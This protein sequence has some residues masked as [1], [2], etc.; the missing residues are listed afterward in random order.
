[1]AQ[2]S[3]NQQ[4]LCL[5]LM[6]PLHRAETGLGKGKC[7]GSLV[8]AGNP[9]FGVSLWIFDGPRVHWTGRASRIRE[10]VVFRI[11]VV[12]V[13]IMSFHRGPMSLFPL[14]SVTSIEVEV[15]GSAS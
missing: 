1:V 12:L 15:S 2:S 8:F 10:D 9:I 11:I 7:A 3:G 13:A 6:E 14:S 5:V 4:A